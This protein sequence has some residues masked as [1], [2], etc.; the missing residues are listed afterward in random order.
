[1]VKN[2]TA[3]YLFQVICFFTNYMFVLKRPKKNISKTIIML[4]SANKLIFSKN[5]ILFNLF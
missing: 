5:Q 3:I 4:M 1:M 2:F